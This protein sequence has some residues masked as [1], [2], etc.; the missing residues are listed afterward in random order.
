M[1]FG[2]WGFG[3]W[4]YLRLTVG[5]VEPGCWSITPP[6]PPATPDRHAVITAGHSAD[7]FTR[8]L[9]CPARAWVFHGSPIAATADG[10]TTAAQ[11]ISL[12]YVLLQHEA[13]TWVEDARL[14]V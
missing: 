4:I 6:P 5:Q 11:Q 9:G 8:S 10:G 12:T 13:P 2:V 14:R 7:V 3:F 1:G